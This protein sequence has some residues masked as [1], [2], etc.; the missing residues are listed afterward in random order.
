[1]LSVA[2]VT[3]IGGLLTECPGGHSLNDSSGSGSCHSPA[4]LGAAS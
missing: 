3:M 2:D 1:M 4:I